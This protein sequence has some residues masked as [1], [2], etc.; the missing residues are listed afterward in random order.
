[1]TFWAIDT[2]D[3]E[4]PQQIL[5]SSSGTRTPTFDILQPGTINKS[6]IF[7]WKSSQTPTNIYDYGYVYEQIKGEWY[8]WYEWDRPKDWYPTNHVNVAL[9][10]PAG[11]NYE[12]FINEFK[13]TFYDIAS[14]VLY[15]HN[16]IDVYIFG[17]NEKSFGFL[18][19]PTYHTIEVTLS[20]NP[21][22]QVNN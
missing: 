14:T 7:I 9:E 17:Y 13:K 5:I 6:K 8:E 11:V 2:S 4:N 19:A 3:P 16:I 1:M 12:D 18:G 22:L 10:I 20:N 21:A 15:I